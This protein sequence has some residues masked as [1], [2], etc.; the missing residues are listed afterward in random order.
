MLK[1]L[2]ILRAI[3][4]NIG[5][6]GVGAY[7]MSLGGDPTLLSIMTLLVVGAYNGLEIGDYLALLQAYQE[8]QDAASDGADGDK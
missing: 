3:V 2:K 1:Q 6:L 4:V 5:V 7:G 8:V